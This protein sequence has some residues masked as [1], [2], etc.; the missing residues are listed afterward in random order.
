MRFAWLV[1]A[2]EDG[3]Y[4][5]DF[6]RGRG[7]TASLMRSI[8]PAGGFFADGAPV[9][10]NQR[11]RAGQC[12]SF[13]LPPEP[14]TDVA[15]QELPITVVYEDR[16]AMALNKPAGLAV[17]PTRGYPDGTLANAFRGLMARRGLDVP[18]RPINRLDRGVSGLV[19]CALNAYAAPLLAASAQKIYYALAEGLVEADEGVIDAP[20]APTS[21][22]II[23]R[24]VRADGKP[25]RTAYRVLARGGG[26]TLLAVTPLT[27]RTH[28]IRLHF[29]SI[30]HPLAGDDLY[31]GSSALLG[32]PALHCGEI[33]FCAPEE[34]GS[35]VVRCPP[36]ADLREAARLCGCLFP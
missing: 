20:I 5:R 26:H 19:L 15:A 18:F 32:R 3:R 10:T 12:V 8:K 36:A 30:G 28:Q 31:G 13:A 1:S 6:L 24:C 2:S 25:S 14:S 34:G 27:G 9:H 22:S 21:D 7:M 11:V 35:R 29:S 17:H 33:S 23:K 4:L 16:Y